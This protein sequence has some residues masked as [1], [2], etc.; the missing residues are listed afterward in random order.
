M[1]LN[2][3]FAGILRPLVRL[4]WPIAGRSGHTVRMT[5]SK[6]PEP[7]RDLDDLT[8]KQRRFLGRIAFRIPQLIKAILSG[9]AE[10]RYDLG[11]RR[12]E[13]GRQLKLELVARAPENQWKGIAK[14]W[15]SGPTGAHKS[16]AKEG[17]AKKRSQ[18][19]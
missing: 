10:C 11:T 4:H 1:D 3:G 9:E 19:C 18:G 14:T 17:A 8:V 7:I 12:L 6:F 13:D 5:S 15:G 2:G 16:E